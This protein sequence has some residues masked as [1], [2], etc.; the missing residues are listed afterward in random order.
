MSY[1][2]RVELGDDVFGNITRINNALGKIEDQLGA[3]KVKLDN[4]QQQMDAA[5]AE[6]NKPFQ[7]EAELKEKSARLAELDA[8]L[9]ISGK[10]QETA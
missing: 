6:L 1:P 3:H 10:Q 8:L 4:L 2:T 5:Q 9:N 7:Y